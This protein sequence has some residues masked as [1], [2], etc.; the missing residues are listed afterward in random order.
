MLESLYYLTPTC[1]YNE[2]RT[3][4]LKQVDSPYVYTD[5]KSLEMYNKE[6]FNDDV[7]EN[8]TYLAID[9]SE[10]TLVDGKIIFTDPPFQSNCDQVLPIWKSDLVSSNNT[11]NY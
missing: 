8:G 6:I 1:R 4:L 7:L 10:V 5:H 3:K 2:H 9:N 11:Q